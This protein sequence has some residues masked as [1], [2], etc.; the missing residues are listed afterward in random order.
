MKKINLSIIILFFCLPLVADNLDIHIN[1][2]YIDESPGIDGDIDA[3]YDSFEKVC[4]FFQ[5][6]PQWGRPG[7]ERTVAYFGY[8]DEHLYVAFK[9]VDEDPDAIR[10]KLGK[11]EDFENS[12][13]VTLFLDTFN[14][15]RRAFIFGTTPFGIQFDGTRDDESHRRKQDFAWDALWYSKG[16]IHDWGYFV[17]IK[18]PFKSI[19][20]PSSKKQEWGMVAQRRIPR[21]G[22]SSTSVHMSRGVRGFLSQASTLVI[23]RD[24]K[25]GR[26]FEIVPTTVAAGTGDDKFKPEFGA[27]F[28]YGITSNLTVDL[29]YNP[30]F[31][32]IESDAGRIDINQRFA[33]QYPEKRPFFLESNT[34]FQ[35][36]LNLFYSRRIADP[37]WGVKL[38]GRIGKSSIGIISGRDESSYEDLDDIS[39]GGADRATVNVFRY[40]YRLKDS[41][42]V[43]VYASQ[44]RW[45]GKTNLVFSADSFLKFNNFV[46]NFQ[47]AYSKTGPQ[48]GN[49]VNSSLSYNTRK[50]YATL[51]YKHISSDFD[52]QVGFLRRV[53]YW[54]Y[55]LFTGYNFF[56]E[57]EYLRRIGPNIM[58]TQ[59]FDWK[60]GAVLDTNF[61]LSV[62]GNSFKN[63]HFS[64]RVR[65]GRENYEGL[66]FDK[67]SFS[68][69]YRINLTKT[70]SLDTE[71]RFGDAI[72]YDE[73]N[74]YLGYSY[75]AE[76]GTNLTLFTRVNMQFSYNNYFFF[77]GP[78][79]SLEYKMNIFRIKNT[80]LLNRY[81]SSRL[82]Y[83]YNDYYSDHYLS[84][85]MS[86]EL[87]PGTALHVGATASSYIED[88]EKIKNWSIFLKIS[89]LF[90]I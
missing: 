45:N 90:R 14:T 50:M 39:E 28:K 26:N 73:D 16:K 68:L 12:D 31:S 9:C 66:D 89:Y 79:G 36:P 80:V 5:S 33:L 23:D 78:G 54:T 65:M 43:G 57:K 44:K 69:D 71:F 60:T 59:N 24:I 8:D 42:Y 82:I 15:R 41:S 1:A 64:G 53:D 74:P 47:G 87:N 20:F 46:F 56:P 19:R 6:E 22:E 72:N 67:L 55:Y 11:R 35:T 4:G 38:T 10:A 58:F 32:Q 75:S 21:K 88:D 62:R 49:A 77:D 7:T 86:Y 84:L 30:D 63:S 83:Q 76:L 61:S 40:M 13:T 29:A 85:L 52:A 34:I 27:S 25:P 18:I 37:R 3:V 81:L 51:G 2:R 48:N 17:E 70:F